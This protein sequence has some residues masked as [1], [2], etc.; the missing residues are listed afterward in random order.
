[1]IDVA[2]VTLLYETEA[3]LICSDLCMCMYASLI[4][5]YWLRLESSWF[6]DLLQRHFL[7]AHLKLNDTQTKIKRSYPSFVE[8]P[9][10]PV[11]NSLAHRSTYWVHLWLHYLPLSLTADAE[12]DGFQ[13]C[14]SLRG[15]WRSRTCSPNTVRSTGRSRQRTAAR[16]SSAT[17][18]RNRTWAKSVSL[19][20]LLGILWTPGLG[21]LI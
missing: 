19:F 4:S 13:T 9:Y 8:Y 12:R 21:E 7:R 18:S 2:C 10:L 15:M 6:I 1:M 16:K 3:A 11:F 20:L 5:D 14:R 17:S